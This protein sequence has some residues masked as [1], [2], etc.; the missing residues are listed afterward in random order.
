MSIEARIKNLKKYSFSLFAFYPDALG[1]I[2]TTIKKKELLF[3]VA[4]HH[5]A[6]EKRRKK[7]R[8]PKVKVKTK[9]KLNK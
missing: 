9:T 3:R 8:L 2:T 7:K 5:N 4:R 1:G 6:R